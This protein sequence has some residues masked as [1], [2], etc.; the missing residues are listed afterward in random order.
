MHI[1]FDDIS[2]EV[3]A[4]HEINVAISTHLSTFAA[5]YGRLTIYE[6]TSNPVLF[7]NNMAVYYTRFAHD[8]RG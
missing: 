7:A 1:D 2:A 4:T 6:G 3:E 5:R 8:N